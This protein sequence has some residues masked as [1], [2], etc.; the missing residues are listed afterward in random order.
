MHGLA[1][2]ADQ[3]RNF[4]QRQIAL[5][6][7]RREGMFELHDD[8]TQLVALHSLITARFVNKKAT[9]GVDYFSYAGVRCAMPKKFQARTRPKIYIEQHRQAAKLSQAELAA[10]VGTTDETICRWETGQR[11]L[12]MEA[13]HALEL[14]L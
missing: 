2:A 1:A 5:L 14:A 9:A 8:T 13:E 11:A 10:L 3:V 6:A 12:S 4:L 7:E